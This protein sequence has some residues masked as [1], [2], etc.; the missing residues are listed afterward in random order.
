MLSSLA[1]SVPFLLAGLQAATVNAVP[2]ISAVGSKF[3]YENGTQFY[4]KGIAYQLTPSDPLVDT[5]QCKR[6]IA[7][8]S[9]LGTNSIRVYHVDPSAN[10]KGCMTALADADFPHWNETQFDRFKAVL[11]EFQKYE[12]TAGVLVGNEVLT[13]AEGSAAAPY[14]LAAARDIKAYRDK[15][16]Y[17]EI[18]VG[19]SA[20]DIP[21]LRPML[22]N[23]LGCSTN[24]SERLDFY[25]LNAYEWC[26]DSSYQQSGYD[27]LQKNATDYPIPIFFSE[28]G[29]NTPKPRTFDDQAAIFG[30]QMADTWSGSIIYEWLEEANN[31][32]L[33]SYG[34][35]VK[36][37]TATATSIED[38]FT[39]QGTPTPVSPDF[40]NLKS[41]WATL[42]PTGVALS[43]Y[44]KSATGL[45]IEC[46][47]STSG[48][49]N[50]DPSSPLPTLG[51]T[52]KKGSDSSATTSGASGTG[53]SAAASSTKEGAAFVVTA[54][55]PI[56]ERLLAGS[57]VLSGMLGALALWL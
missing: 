32:G 42:N 20:A 41:Q 22:Q 55:S 15:K 51:Q 1:L 39:R 16:G 7:R 25:S 36:P 21:D 9:E 53:S 43:D 8:M 34:P 10:H 13:T 40:A 45:S 35:S 52:Y 17:R 57:I 46:P 12:N 48:G 24:A 33:I 54:S 49:W 30:D 23:Y 2:T 3:F 28:T 47:A 29:C 5:A 31:Y 56:T 37:A 27:M 4:I 50:V 6:D 14:V 19:Y 44:K 11:D 26:G 18:P 38:G